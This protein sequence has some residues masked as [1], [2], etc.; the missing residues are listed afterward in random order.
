MSPSTDQQADKVR[1][2]VSSVSK[3]G[4]RAAPGAAVRCY[5]LT[6]IDIFFLRVFSMYLTTPS[7]QIGGQHVLG[8][9]Q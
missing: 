4:S 2:R 9:P 5:N 1:V 6:Y 7:G 8:H 3:S